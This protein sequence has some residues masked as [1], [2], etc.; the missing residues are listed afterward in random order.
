MNTIVAPDLVDESAWHASLEL[1]LAQR[2]AQTR[3]YRCR[4]KGPLYVQKAFYPE[5]DSLA[6]LY[7][8]HPPGALF[9]ATISPLMSTWRTPPGR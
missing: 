2:E 7:L 8:L 9:Q 6:H 1:S 5:G 3:L 4:H